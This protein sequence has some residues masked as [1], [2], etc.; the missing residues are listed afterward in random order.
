MSKTKYVLQ[1]LANLAVLL[2]FLLFVV[3]PF[4]SN[5]SVTQE[6]IENTPL[7]EVPP[8]EQQGNRGEDEVH[9]PGINPNLT[10]N[11]GELVHGDYRPPLWNSI[12]LTITDPPPNSFC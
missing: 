3:Q 10:E 8:E 11:S 12:S 7:N 9:P 5:N 6:I 2:I 1:Y 4:S